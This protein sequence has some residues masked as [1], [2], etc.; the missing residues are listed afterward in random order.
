M[1]KLTQEQEE[2]ICWWI[3][4]WYMK[5]KRN[6][7][8]G[9]QEHRLGVAK[10]DLKVMIC[11]ANKLLVDDANEILEAYENGEEFTCVVNIEEEKSKAEEAAKNFLK[12]KEE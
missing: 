4:E 6:I 12:E 9:G 5:W 8:S 7:V 10:E 2:F 11:E 3:G 1:K